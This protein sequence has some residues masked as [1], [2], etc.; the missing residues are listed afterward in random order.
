MQ[1]KF[2][3]FCLLFAIFTFAVPNLA[4]RSL[5]KISLK[6]FTTSEERIKSHGYPA[7]SHFIETED[8]YILN[9]FRIPYSHK[10][11]NQNAYR[12]VILLQHGLLSNSDC[13]L[14]SGPDHS[15]A[16]LLADAGYDVWLGNARGNIYSRDNSKISLNNPKFWHFS[17][18][19]I[20]VVD[21]AAMIDYILETTNEKQ[22]HYAGHSQGTTVYFVLMSDRPEYNSKIKS[23]HMLAPCAFFGHGT[24]PVFALFAPLIGTPGTLWESMLQD[25]ELMPQNKLINRM[26]DTSCGGAGIATHL[27]ENMYLRF[28]G[29]GYQNTNISSMQLLLETHPAG[30]SSNQG[31]HYI[32]S[33]VSGKFRHY[34]MGEK[35]NQQTYNQPTPPDY[36][37]SQITAPTYLYSSQNDALCAPAD[38]DTLV[39]AMPY[40]TEDYRIPDP[41]WNHLDF[42]V[43]DGMK[44]VL[45]DLIIENCAKH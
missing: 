29:D 37:L 3:L 34:D 21:I 31:I 35:K 26:V 8:G 18:H 23:A 39:A 7:E 16:Y 9:L 11:Q 42:I 30:S 27:C 24:S 20:G 17:W 22:L 32:Q 10:L 13:W 1:T 33:H 6:K 36:D 19:E 5:P 28:I 40:L 43:A 14:T 41:S 45:N 12:P 15:L 38:V 2:K 44:E 4:K 25:L